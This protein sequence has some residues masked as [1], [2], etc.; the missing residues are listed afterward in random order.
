L[1]VSVF[2]YYLSNL[3]KYSLSPKLCHQ[4]CT[5]MILDFRQRGGKI[6][7]AIS[8]QGVIRSTSCLFLGLGFWGRWIKW[9]YFRFD[10]IQYVVLILEFISMFQD[11]FYSCLHHC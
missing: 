3:C 9:R 6:Q 7:M 8:P 4:K 10:Q 2:K 1:H 5:K 11:H